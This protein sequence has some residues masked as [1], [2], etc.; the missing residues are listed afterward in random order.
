MYQL[1]PEYYPDPTPAAAVA[2]VMSAVCSPP[3][4]GSSR[5][6]VPRR[7]RPVVYICSPFSGNE[8]VN[9][10]RARAFCRFAVRSGYLPIAPHLL[11]PQFMDD[12][13]PDER[14]LAL[15]F[16]NVLLGKCHQLWVFGDRI[17]EGMAREIGRARRR[18][19]RIRYFT[20]DFEEVYPE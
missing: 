11:F 3:P 4:R 1:S 6:P 7:E 15:S 19:M 10:H 2:R 8:E 12:S 13:D 14:E 16:C 9:R 5:P 18:A 20:N 17:S